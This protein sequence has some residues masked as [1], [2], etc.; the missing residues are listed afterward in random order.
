MDNITKD[1]ITDPNLHFHFI[2]ALVDKIK[3]GHNF[4][5]TYNINEKRQ[6]MVDGWPADTD[7]SAA[8]LDWKW[9][10]SH[11]LNKG[12]NNYLIPDIKKDEK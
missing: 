4:V 12:L 3:D 1:N 7:D 5:I 2:D 11:D 9:K 6:K 8:R 10:A